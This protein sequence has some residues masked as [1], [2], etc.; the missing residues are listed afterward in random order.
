MTY[1]DWPP[2]SVRNWRAVLAMR[3]PDWGKLA[4]DYDDTAAAA[5]SRRLHELRGVI[6]GQV[7]EI[8]NLL[9]YIASQIRE[10][11]TGDVPPR[12]RGQR[13]AGKMLDDVEILLEATGLKSEFAAHIQ[14]IRQTI[15]QRNAIVHAVIY[16]GF[17]YIP[18]D[19][20]R[21]SVI[22][23]LFDNDGTQGSG[24]TVDEEQNI[25]DEIDEIEL[26]HQ[27]DRSHDAL[28]KCVD[29]WIRVNDTLPQMELQ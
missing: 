6:I 10:R 29:I 21:S 8:E 5:E 17:S 22:V 12:R 19:D 7:A 14:C 13:G 23:L 25:I 4:E 9:L 1:N 27:L 16:V 26:E 18:F 15:R 2:V 20:S 3:D 28:D 11:S 24:R